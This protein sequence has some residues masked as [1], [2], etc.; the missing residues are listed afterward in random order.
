[1]RATEFSVNVNSMYLGQVKLEYPDEVVFVYN[2]LYIALNVSPVG[3]VYKFRSLK[4]SISTGKN[5]VGSTGIL[6]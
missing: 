3:D 4:F 5:Q 1:M 2:P 6:M